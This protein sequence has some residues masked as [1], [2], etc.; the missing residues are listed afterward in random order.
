MQK[1]DLETM[2]TDLSQTCRTTS[3][4]Y[5]VN[6]GKRKGRV[7][8]KTLPILIIHAGIT[9]LLKVDLLRPGQEVPTLQ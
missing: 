6:K 1:S 3:A 5:G 7:Q 9:A 8:K 2:K 4:I